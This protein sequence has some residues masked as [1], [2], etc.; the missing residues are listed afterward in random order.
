[1]L[2][3]FAGPQ[4][5]PGNEPIDGYESTFYDYNN[6]YEGPCMEPPLV[7]DEECGSNRYVC[8]KTGKKT[9]LTCEIQNIFGAEY[10]YP[11]GIC[12]YY[13]KYFLQ[14]IF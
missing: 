6:F 13:L 4:P 2:S 1:M 12:V 9:R 5:I 8:K 3:C 11:I 10:Y 7:W 14:P